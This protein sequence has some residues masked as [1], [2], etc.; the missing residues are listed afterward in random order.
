MFSY[1]S[2]CIVPANHE[3]LEQGRNQSGS[4][5]LLAFL[6]L[7]LCRRI[8]SKPSVAWNR[9]A[10]HTIVDE[11]DVGTYTELFLQHYS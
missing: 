3:P 7:A 4:L 8:R 6:Q 10:K 5:G 11:H 9:D 1:S 2:Q